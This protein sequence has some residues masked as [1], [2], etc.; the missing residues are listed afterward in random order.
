MHIEMELNESQVEL[1]LDEAALM[2]RFG[3]D[4]KQLYRAAIRSVNQAARRYRQNVVSALGVEGIPANPARARVNVKARRG[5]PQSDVWFGLLGF[6]PANFGKP[7]LRTGRG[8]QVGKHDFDG[9]FPAYYRTRPKRFGV[10][11]RTQK[12]RYPIHRVKLDRTDA[13][14]RAIDRFAREAERDV[15]NNLERALS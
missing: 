14:E 11:R 3:V 2:D 13:M 5:R 8:V 1:S 4:E 7:I 10:W 15:M 12:P 6:D 9:A